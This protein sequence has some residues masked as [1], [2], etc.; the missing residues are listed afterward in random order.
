[1][2][3]KQYYYP[4]LDGLRFFAFFIVFLHHVLIN[5]H[6]E[7]LIINF[8]LVVIQKNGW[9]GVDLFF[10]LSGFLIT[11]LLLKERAKYGKYSLKN[12]WIRRSLRIWPLYYL[13][14]MV[15]FF[16]FPFIPLPGFYSLDS[17]LL[18]IKEQ[19]PFYLLFLGN[20]HVSFFGYSNFSTISHLWTISLEEQFY[21]LWPIILLFINSLKKAYLWVFII[22]FFSL[23]FRFIFALLGTQHPGIYT[24]TIARIDT[25]TMGGLL[26]LLNFYNPYFLSKV[27]RFT[28][29]P[30]QILVFSTLLI[31]LYKF[32]FF[33]PG[34]VFQV[35]FG[36]F[37]I[38]LFMSYFIV[39][40]LYNK[41]LFVRIT[42][43]PIIVYLGKI[44][45]GLYIWHILAINIARLL[46]RNTS[47]LGILLISF[48]LT[49]FLGYVSYNFYERIFLNLKEKY[50]R[51]HSRP[52]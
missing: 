32:Y 27:R 39:N 1:M 37:I 42:S 33:N 16:V 21:L 23:F 50:T 35:V 26:A 18:H 14:L 45:Y 48:L 30:F 9:V 47:I 2:T 12:F 15:G 22:V 10:V 4:S 20:W 19:L 31:I 29:P 28:K 7:N 41:S 44:S 34:M 36:Y 25:L 52:I 43:H 6:S 13:A 51:I 8:F 38:T 46:L 3:Y 11:T 24:N 49:I 40:A 5:I 17:Y